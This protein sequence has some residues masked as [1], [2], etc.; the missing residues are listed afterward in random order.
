MK[1]VLQFIAMTLALA[2]AIMAEDYLTSTDSDNRAG[3]ESN[4]KDDFSR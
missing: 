1:E 2:L 4:E 3:G